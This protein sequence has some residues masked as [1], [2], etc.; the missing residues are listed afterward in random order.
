MCVGMYKYFCMCTHTHSIKCIQLRFT[1][2]IIISF[3][4]AKT[5]GPSPPGTCLQPCL[6]PQPF[7]KCNPNT[8]LCKCRH[9]CLEHA[10]THTFK[11]P[12]YQ[13]LF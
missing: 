13:T 9:P 5:Q 2:F 7:A 1:N 6:P 10:Y 8:G 11:A 4:F 3:S 12:L